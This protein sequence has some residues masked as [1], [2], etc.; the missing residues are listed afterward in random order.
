[1]T[2]LESAEPRLRTEFDPSVRIS[3]AE[4]KK[5]KQYALFFK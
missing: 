4:H 1:M 2:R 3:Y 5:C